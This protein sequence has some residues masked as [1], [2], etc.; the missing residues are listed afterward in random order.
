MLGWFRE[1]GIAKRLLGS[2]RKV[3]LHPKSLHLLIG[4]IMKVETRSKSEQERVLGR[5]N[6]PKVY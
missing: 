3:H 1:G 4:E 6:N 5:K 2:I